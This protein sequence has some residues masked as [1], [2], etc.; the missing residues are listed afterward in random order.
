M[1]IPTFPVLPLVAYPVKRSLVTKTVKEE[2]MAGPTFRYPIRTRPKW[3]WEIS[4]DALREKR[5]S[6]SG[7]WTTLNSFLLSILGPAFPFYYLDQLDNAAT[8]AQ[9]GTGDGV[10]TTF[11]L[12]RVIGSFFEPLYGAFGGSIASN[13]LS[14]NPSV[15]VNGVLQ[16]FGTAYTISSTGLVTFTSA[17]GAAA[18]ITWTGYFAF[19]CEMDDDVVEQTLFMSGLYAVPKIAFSSKLL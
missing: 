1:T 16:T 8:T 12:G 13:A 11:Q 18:V 10:T 19:L 17:P 7:E 3:Q 14:G 5:P 15:Y 2:A 4:V 6:V 9:F